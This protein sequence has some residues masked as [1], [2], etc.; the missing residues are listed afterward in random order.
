MGRLGL[1]S[2]FQE[3]EL[4][5]LMWSPKQKIHTQMDPHK[6]S[7]STSDLGGL[8]IGKEPTSF[9]RHRIFRPRMVQPGVGF[10]RIDSQSGLA[11]PNSSCLKVV[12]RGFV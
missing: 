2:F 9:D 12:G 3:V 10:H 11:V 8:W 4:G 1:V 6:S 7:N 5:G